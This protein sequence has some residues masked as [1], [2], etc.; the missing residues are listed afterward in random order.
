MPLTREQFARTEVLFFEANQ[1]PPAQWPGFLSE[2]CSDDAVVRDEVRALLGLDNGADVIRPLQVAMNKALHRAPERSRHIGG[3]IGAYRIVEQIGEGGMGLVFRAEQQEPVQRTVALKLIRAGMDSPDVVARFESE[4]QALAMMNHPHVA[5]VFDAGTTDDGRHY[6]VM[7]HVADASPITQWCDDNRASIRQRIELFIEV[8]DAVHHAHQRGVIHR[9][10][11]PTNI[12]VTT[13]DGKPVPKVIDFGVAKAIE[14]PLAGQTLVTHFGQLIGTPEYMSPEQADLNIQDVDTRSDIYSLGVILYE[15]LTGTPPL[16]RSRLSDSGLDQ[17]LRTIREVDPPRPS[18]RVANGTD[19]AREIAQRRKTDPARLARRL[20][21]ELDWI[22]GKSLEKSRE[23][24][25]SSA[26]EL[27]DDLRRYT[28]DQPVIAGPPGTLYRVRK[29]VRRHRIPVAAGALLALVMIA[30]IAG[31]TWQAVRALRAERTAQ[32]RLNDVRKLAEEVLFNLDESMRTQGPTRTRQLIVSTA[33][34][35]LDRL[36]SEA[37]ED[38]SAR[39]D[40]MLG[41]ARVGATQYA[42]MTTEGG[43]SLGDL[44]GAL[45]SYNKALELAR[46]IAK[47]APSPSAQAEVA[48]CLLYLGDTH[49]ALEDYS[50]A[51]RAYD[52]AR[53]IFAALVAANPDDLLRRKQVALL[54]SRRGKAFVALNRKDDAI[55]AHTEALKVHEL[56]ASMFPDDRDIR[57]ILAMNKQTIRELTDEAGAMKVHLEH[58]RQMIPMVRKLL[59]DDPSSPRRQRDLALGLEQMV[60]LRMAAENAPARDLLADLQESLRLQEALLRNDPENVVAQEDL[61]RA[62]SAYGKLTMQAD[63]LDE[64]IKAYERAL[65]LRRKLM[66][67]DGERAGPRRVAQALMDLVEP[68]REA[69]RIDDAI[70][71]AREASD[72]S[73]TRVIAQNDEL[74]R[75]QLLRALDLLA[76]ACAAAGRTHDADAARRRWGKYSAP[77]SAPSAPPISEALQR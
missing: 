19:N 68:Y 16:D 6:F 55:A 21:G 45:R 60:A 71:A 31:T 43:G 33:L 2:R 36:A 11:K 52:E 54:H 29:F 23:R 5:R 53:E 70:A 47:D 50:S 18:T 72:L 76:E 69:G 59:E 28:N 30:G 57:V 38:P 39:R 8:C 34:R 65:G 58:M 40:V 13:V 4:R 46:G 75:E 67:V 64:S 3:C 25:Y 24:R 26:A 73:E 37:A 41:Y 9:D 27:A 20:R 51:F 49:V 42:L 35:Y 14:R 12:L 56:S 22:I 32:R 1:L 15:L 10:L 17:V 7:E 66:K 74:S 77:V 61:A 62:L 63:M 44:P 48:L